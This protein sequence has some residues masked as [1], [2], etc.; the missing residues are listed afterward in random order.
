MGGTCIL[1]KFRGFGFGPQLIGNAVSVYRRMGKKM[2]QATPAKYN[3]GAANFYQRNGFEP[4]GE[5]TD[6][7]GESFILRRNIEVK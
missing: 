2:L 7:C 6:E 3:P 4:V 5:Y 1:E